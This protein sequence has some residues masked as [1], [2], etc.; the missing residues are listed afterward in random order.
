MCGSNS[1]QNGIC[2]VCGFKP[3]LKREYYSKKEWQNMLNKGM[4]VL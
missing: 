2:T 1:V 4:I 3:N